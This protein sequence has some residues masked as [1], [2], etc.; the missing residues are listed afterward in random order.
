MWDVVFN[1]Y[2]VKEHISCNVVMNPP[3]K[4]VEMQM[5]IIGGWVMLA[6]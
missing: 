5:K 6:E 4:V 1:N 2:F 3:K